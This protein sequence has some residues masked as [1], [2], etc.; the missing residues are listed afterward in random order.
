MFCYF[1]EAYVFGKK[2]YTK[3]KCYVSKNVGDDRHYDIPK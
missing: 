2:K 1:L 3:V